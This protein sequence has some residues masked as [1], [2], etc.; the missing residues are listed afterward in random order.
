MDGL[1][2]PSPEVRIQNY[3]RAIFSFGK[4]CRRTIIKLVVYRSNQSVRLA[5]L[6]KIYQNLIQEYLYPWI[7]GL[8]S[9]QLA[10]TTNPWHGLYRDAPYL[11]YQQYLF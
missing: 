11:N 9:A 1:L 2:N 6:D 3:C 8:S 5:V 10:E 4:G 7:I